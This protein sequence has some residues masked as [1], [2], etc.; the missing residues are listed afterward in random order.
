MTDTTDLRYLERCIELASEAL[1][2]GD[3]PFGSILVAAD[4]TVLA[5]DRNRVAGGD[6]TRHPE[7]ELARWAA[8]H[9][10]PEDR[11]KATVYTSGEHCPM[12]SA[13]HAWVGLGP[14]V[15]AASTIQL[16]A[17]LTEFGVAPGP[18]NPLPIQQI[19]PNI[20][21]AGPFPELT[22]RVYAL[23]RRFNGR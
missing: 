4:G 12:C 23:H 22:D 13:A 11:A 18:V 20:A 3:E 9:L 16:T 5:E 10:A 21:V 8:A 17:W 19:A 7:F 14:I 15:Y 1:D 2:A 6:H